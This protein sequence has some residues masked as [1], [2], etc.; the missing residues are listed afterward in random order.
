MRLKKRLSNLIASI[1]IL[2]KYVFFFKC[3]WV[4]F[5]ESQQ[6]FCRFRAFELSKEM[7]ERDFNSSN[8]ERGYENHVKVQDYFTLIWVTVWFI[9]II[10]PLFYISI[11]LNPLY[12]T[13]SRTNSACTKNDNKNWCF[14]YKWYLKC[15]GGQRTLFQK[16]TKPTQKKRG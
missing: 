2:S 14:A 10:T 15:I 3:F 16:P 13:S 6:H 4:C 8:A 11:K 5:Y 1:G 7:T 12:H 9:F